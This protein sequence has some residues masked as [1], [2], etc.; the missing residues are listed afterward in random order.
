MKQGRATRDVAAPKQQPISHGVSVTHV[1]DMG[2]M[3][4]NHATGEGPFYV[5][6]ET[7]YQGREGIKAPQPTVTKHHCGS[8]GRH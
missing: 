5:R 3:Q 6:H 2:C 1:A 7:L 8:Q 4:G